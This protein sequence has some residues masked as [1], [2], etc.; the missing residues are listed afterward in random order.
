MLISFIKVNKLRK[1]S[2]LFLVNGAILTLTALFMRFVSLI[3]NIYISNQ[4]GSEAVG[5]FSLVMT[6]YMFFITI[7]TSGLGIAVT[8]IVSEKFAVDDRKSAIKA[9]RTCI[10]FSL[11]LGILAGILIILSSNFITKT[12]LH[13]MISSKTLFYISIVLPFIAMSAC[14]TSYFNAVRK[15]YKNA[16]CQIFEFIVK[17]IATLILLK[18]NINNGVELICIS[19][20][21]ADVISELCSFTLIFILYKMDIRVKKLDYIHSF[22]QRKKI[23]KFAFPVAITSYIRSGLSTL[24]QLIIPSK[25]QE[26]GLS[27]A[28]ALSEYGII[29]G[30]VLPI[31]TFPTVLITSYSMLLIPEFSTY[32]TQKNYK[33]INFISK[34][35][36]KIT[37]AFSFCVCSIFLF[38]SNELGIVIYNNLETGFFFKLLAPLVFFIY[39]DN[40]IDSIL[41]GLNKQ[42]G[43]MCCNILDLSITICFIYFLLPILGVKG[44][45]IS[46]FISEILNFTVSLLQLIK[47]SKMKINI[48]DWLI[49]P[50]FCSINAYLLLSLFHFNFIDLKI[51]LVVNIIEFIIIYILLFFIVHLF[52]KNDT[53]KEVAL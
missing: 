51:N 26:A 17:F 46:I 4:I 11:I 19:L 10:F 5:V 33:A 52:Q 22:G 7:A 40:I 20:I 1:K 16:I 43:V 30:M 2:K 36:F 50:G 3:F 18:I 38:F 31:I 27:Y 21:F 13:E 12:F 29:N 44:Y 53:K 15:G 41:K 25:L 34:K 45:I 24:K 6:V 35:I 48:L 47:Y 9:I 14:I 28:K 49:V 39:M 32:L 23:I 8:C 42:F 37:S